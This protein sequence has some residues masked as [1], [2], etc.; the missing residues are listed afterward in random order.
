MDRITLKDSER[1]SCEI[2]SRCMGYHRP[3]LSWNHGKRQEFEDRRPFLES[4][5][6]D[7]ATK[8]C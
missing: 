1:Q 2:W 3:T 7:G 8:A 5:A 4:K 6:I